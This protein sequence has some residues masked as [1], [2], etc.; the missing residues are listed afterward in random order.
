MALWRPQHPRAQQLF[1]YGALALLAFGVLDLIQVVRSF[2]AFV[3]AAQ[4]SA[5]GTSLLVGAVITPLVEMLLGGAAHGQDPR[6]K[7]VTQVGGGL[8]VLLGIYWMV[9]RGV[10]TTGGPTG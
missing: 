4:K 8:A 1:E 9:T 3:E 10:L 2:A 7:R 5:F 6:W